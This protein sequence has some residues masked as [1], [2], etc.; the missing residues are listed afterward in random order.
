MQIPE[1][2]QGA[3]DSAA[4]EEAV[5]RLGDG[6]WPVLQ[7]MRLGAGVV[8]RHR[9]FFAATGCLCLG[10]LVAFT[11]IPRGDA[12][13][14]ELMALVLAGVA[15]LGHGLVIERTQRDL[16]GAPERQP[17]EVAV[18]WATRLPTLALTALAV[19]G[20][21][22]LVDIAFTP[23]I[24][25]SGWF[26]LLAVEVLMR[27]TGFPMHEVIAGERNPLRALATSARVAGFPGRAVAAR[28]TQWMGMGAVAWAAG[29][30]LAVVTGVG[31]ELLWK[32]TH[33]YASRQWVEVLTALVLV[34][35]GTLGFFA[36]V[37]WVQASWAS[38]HLLRKEEL[39]CDA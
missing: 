15:A 33:S 22:T 11:A 1:K 12:P 35:L 24:K 19:A 8:K 4:T 28:V 23:A 10:A 13:G 38:Y 3:Q 30:L 31:H 5:L 27:F 21:V 36:W 20:V 37:A 14:P 34:P 32:A 7:A 6:S 2:K 16:L 17:G 26:A 25:A 29:M 9:P 39:G 18:D